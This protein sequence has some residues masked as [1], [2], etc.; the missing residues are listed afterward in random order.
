VSVEIPAGTVVVLGGPWVGVPGQDLGVTQGDAGIESV[1]DG[2]VVQ[3][4]GEPRGPW[5]VRRTFGV[6]CTG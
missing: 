1:A 2:C 6:G 4:G 3:R 5:R